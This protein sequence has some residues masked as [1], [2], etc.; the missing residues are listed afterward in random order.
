LAGAGRGAQSHFYDKGQRITREPRLTC[1]SGESTAL[2]LASWCEASMA[3][4]SMAA[5][6]WHQRNKV[7]PPPSHRKSAAGLA[8]KQQKCPCSGLAQQSRACPAGCG[9]HNITRGVAVQFAR[10]RA[11]A[12]QPFKGTLFKAFNKYG[13]NRT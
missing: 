9:C 4:A 2:A 12:R 1:S 10:A 11:R 5:L 3:Q 13:F 7:I 6:V 8:R